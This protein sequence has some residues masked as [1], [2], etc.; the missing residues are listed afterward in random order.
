MTIEGP[1]P[2]LSA[3]RGSGIWMFEGVAYALE[4]PKLRHKILTSA[5]VVMDRGTIGP[6]ADVEL[7]SIDASIFFTITL[8]HIAAETPH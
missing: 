8:L 7:S 4:V 5:G 6:A 2:G 1:T 3:K